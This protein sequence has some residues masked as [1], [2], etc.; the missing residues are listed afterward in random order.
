M[1][2]TSI[3]GK[4]FGIILIAALLLGGCGQ[5]SGSASSAAKKVTQTPTKVPMKVEEGLEAIM[6]DGGIDVLVEAREPVISVDFTVTGADAIKMVSFIPNRN[7]FGQVSSNSG[8][9]K[10]WKVSMSVSASVKD[11]P[12]GKIL[13]GKVI[14]RQGSGNLTFKDMILTGPKVN[15]QPNQVQIKDIVFPATIK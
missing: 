3:W 9:E 5:T 10:E 7:I 1:T 11:F 6:A 8:G 2:K 15:G 12:V 4:G 13:L 14:C